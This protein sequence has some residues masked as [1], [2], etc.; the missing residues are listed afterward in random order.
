MKQRNGD[1]PSAQREW[2]T[3]CP[4]ALGIG[5]ILTSLLPLNSW[6][7]LLSQGETFQFPGLPRSSRPAWKLHGSRASHR[8]KPTRM[9]RPSLP[10]PCVPTSRVWV[11]TQLPSSAPWRVRPSFPKLFFLSASSLPDLGFYE[12]TALLPQ[13]L[14]PSYS[15]NSI[16]C[17]IL[18]IN[19]IILVESDKNTLK[20]ISTKTRKK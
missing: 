11:T 16:Q 4:E 3:V 2:G 7:H 12:Q 15:S 17:I 18:F 8:I 9:G 14:S 6:D 13:V 1:L 19:Q 10:I 20:Q 5:Q